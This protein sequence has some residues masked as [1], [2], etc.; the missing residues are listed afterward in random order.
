[1]RSMPYQRYWLSLL[2]LGRYRINYNRVDPWAVIDTETRKRNHSFVG[3]RVYHEEQVVA[4]EHSRK[5]GEADL[6]NE[7]IEIANPM[8]PH[9]KIDPIAAT[10][11][12]TRERGNAKELVVALG[13][14]L[15]IP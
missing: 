7:L 14:G 15:R 2:G 8:L 5:I 12:A 10:L 6:L 9:E 11:I 13:L 3:A 4:I 1:M